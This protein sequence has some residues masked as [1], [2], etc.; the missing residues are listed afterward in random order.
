LNA[1]AM[2]ASASLCAQLNH[3]ADRLVLSLMREELAIVTEPEKSRAHGTR[4]PSLKL[5]GCLP[6]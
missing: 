3:F 5:E 6:V 1:A 2:T 4:V